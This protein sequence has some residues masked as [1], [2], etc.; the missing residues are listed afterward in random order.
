MPK[1]SSKAAI[2]SLVHCLVAGAVYCH[3]DTGGWLTTAY[4]LDD[5]NVINL[6]LA[7]FEP[8]AIASVLAYW[9]W[10]APRLY[11][12]LRLL[13]L[14]QLVIGL[15]FLVFFLVFVFTWRPK[16]M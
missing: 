11:R 4:R 8:F 12:I 3:L 9:I 2:L 10:R 13:F 14:G 1:Q 15:G 5:P 6:A 7:L 16:L